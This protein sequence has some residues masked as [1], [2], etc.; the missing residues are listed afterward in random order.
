MAD[1]SKVASGATQGAAAGTA[2]L[3][4]WG[5][6]IGGAVG[7]IGGLLGGGNDGSG[8]ARDSANIANQIIQEISQAPDISKPLLLEKYKQA[9][10]L[11]PEMEQYITAA[12]PK[13]A[14]VSTDPR[15]KD[16]Q[17]QALQ[18]IQQRATSG[19]T[20]GDRAA[21][22][23]A[24]LQSQGDTQSK[25]AQIQQQAAQRGQAGMGSDLAAQLSAAQGGANIESANADR[26]AMQSQNAAEQAAAQL[27]QMG[28]Q[29]QQQQFGQ[30][31]QKASAADEMNRFN[32]Q[33]QLAQQQRNVGAANQAQAGNLANLQS[34]NNA[35]VSG[36]NQENAAQLQRQ[37]QQWNANTGLAAMKS[38]AQFNAGNY[39]YG[40]D[41]GDAQSKQ[42][43]I[44]G[45]GGMAGNLIGAFSS[46]GSGGSSA[47]GDGS[48]AS[49][50]PSE[51]ASRQSERGF[52]QGGQVHNYKNGGHVPGQ[53]NVPGDSPKN[54][55]VKAMLSPGELVIPRSLADSK[56]GRELL[57]LIKAHNSVKHKLNQE[58]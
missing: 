34:I 16:A 10:V 8:Q 57:K 50:S 22:N 49:L 27:G 35:N 9:G 51:L 2:V 20:A 58:D 38:G 21:L 48:D 36:Q 37:M 40:L 28:S 53:A 13:A 44:G 19:L 32:V 18:Q 24:R 12:Q 56:L 45:I 5:T 7:A 43:L 47:S 3:P 33:N 46:G 26:L 6:V 29:M 54:D 1:G 17:M 25:I 31:Y 52:S 15:F 4:G 39:N 42:N 11:T 41:K 55:T 14:S 30:E 23:Q